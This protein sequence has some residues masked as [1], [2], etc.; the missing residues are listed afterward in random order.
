MKKTIVSI[1]L[2]NY[3]STGN[4]VSGIAN[5]AKQSK[6]EYFVA[7]RA[8]ER[9]K[10][11][12]N[13]D[14]VIGTV[15]LN[16]V[17]EKIGYFWGNLGSNAKMT[18]SIFIKKIDK[19]KPDIIHLH[20]IHSEYINLEIL[21]KY[22]KRKNIRVIWTLHDCWSFTG[23]CPHFQVTKCANWLSGCNNCKYPLEDYP[24]SKKANSN[25][26][27]I[28]KQKLF[29]GVK[30]LTIVTPSKWL[31]GLV[32]Q[33]FLKNYPV[34][35]IH[36]GIDLSIFRPTASEFRAK[37]NVPKNKSILLGVAF[38]WGARKGLDVFVE[39]SKRLDSDKYQIVLV[40]TDD[41]VDKQL[42]QNIISIHCTQNQKE[43]AEIYTAADLFVNPTREENYPTVNMEAIACGTPVLSFRTG[44][45]PE[46]ISEQ[47]GAVVDCDDIDAMEK[48]IIRICTD[49]PFTEEAC[50]ARAKDFD[51]NDKFEDYIKL[52]E[53]ITHSAQRTI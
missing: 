29:C 53:N 6:Y 50:L 7:Y 22:I 35:V 41:N 47:T 8:S 42:P 45:S 25:A 19:I 20:N 4:I 24:Q 31:A 26:L 33:S 13:Q 51:M 48:E 23:R 34:K 14:I 44:G 32:K 16:K 49:K 3:G 38:G 43:L 40:G 30:D 9:N 39:L 36:N 46:I 52:Y 21:F 12:Q 15:F 28:K 2:G 10:K 27:F 5:I 18:T 1:N 17:Y 11:R 37:Y